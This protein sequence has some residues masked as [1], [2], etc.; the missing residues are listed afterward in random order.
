MH[1]C[2][3]TNGNIVLCCVSQERTEYNIKTSSVASWWTSDFMSNIRQQFLNNEQPSACR[4]CFQEEQLGGTSLRQKS[5]KEYKIIEKYAEK[6]I[7]HFEYPAKLPIDIEFQLTNL[8]NLKCL[9]CNESDSS[10]ILTENKILKISNYD[11]KDFTLTDTQLQEIKTLLESKPKMIN[12]R[13]GEPMMVPQIKK[14]LEWAVEQNLLT[15]TSLH[16]TTNGTQYTD[17]WHTLLQKFKD[18]RV[19]LS[20]DA[21]G[22][23]NDYIRHGSTWED[24]EY[25]AKKISSL[26]NVYFLIHCTIQ[27]LNILFV[28]E[29]IAWCKQNNYYFDNNFVTSPDI[30][31]INNLPAELLVKAKNKLQLVHKELAD[32]ISVPVSDKS[33]WHQFCHEINVKDQHRKSNILD[34]IP[35]FK[36][37]WNL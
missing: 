27:N 23:L 6:I 18:V 31:Q 16:L 35:E 12:F 2:I 36:E 4:S 7:K 15:D 17:E 25:T 37:Y 24:I 9:M 26:P 20:V 29:L 34:V 1:S 3:K 13:G 22:K 32:A 33:K 30:Y 14:L 8:C 21:V 28:D 11:Q 10:A 19:M 5:N